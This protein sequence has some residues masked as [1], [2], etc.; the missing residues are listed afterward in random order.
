[1]LG[2]QLQEP[3]C[4]LTS[5]DGTCLN[6]IGERHRDGPT[7]AT[8]QPESGDVKVMLRNKAKLQKALRQVTPQNVSFGGGEYCLALLTC[9]ML[10][11]T[12]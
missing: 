12:A 11:V 5:A 10:G 3:D 8:G 2:F 9:V 7:P 4:Q 6:V 1:M